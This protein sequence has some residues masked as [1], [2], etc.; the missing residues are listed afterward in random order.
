[1]T[2]AIITDLVNSDNTG[3]IANETLLLIN[4]I[5]VIFFKIQ[6]LIEYI[7]WKH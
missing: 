1:M 6:M 2:W 3:D 4:C 5:F 7:L